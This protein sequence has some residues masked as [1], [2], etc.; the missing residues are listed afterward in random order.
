[1][2]EVRNILQTN[3]NFVLVTHMGPDGDAIGSCFGLA[4]ALNSLGKSV[5]VVLGVFPEKYTIIPGAEFLHD[6][7]DLKPDVAIALDCADQS[8]I[9]SPRYLFQ[10]APTTICIDHH[11]TNAGFAKINLIDPAASSTCEIVYNLIK[12][13]TPISYNIAFALYAGILTDTGGFKYD[14]TQKQTLEIAANLISTGIDFTKIYNELLH[15]HSFAGGKALGIVINNMKQALDGRITYSTI[16]ADELISVGAKSFELD[17]AVEY[18]LNTLDTEASV[19]VYAKTPEELQ[20][21]NQ[22]PVKVSFRSKGADVGVV[23][24]RMGGGGHRMASGASGQDVQD[25]LKMALSLLEEEI[26][27]YDKRRNQFI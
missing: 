27:V 11:I 23:A 15:T 1:M 18:L 25:T 14:S 22:P 4:H 21:Q 7:N 17:G 10:D 13:I 19:F 2:D 20:Y 3:D 12:D 5:K 6:G 24:K 9:A 8:R 16:S 26:I